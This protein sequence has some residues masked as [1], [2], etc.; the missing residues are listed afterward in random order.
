PASWSDEMILR[1]IS[2]V[3]TDR[4]S[5]FA[6]RAGALVAAS[7]REGVDIEVIIKGGRI[8]TGYPTNTPKNPPVKHAHSRT[9]GHIQHGQVLRADASVKL[10]AFPTDWSNDTILRH[11]S[12]VASDPASRFR[13]IRS[14]EYVATGRRDGVDMDVTI[15]R[16]T[17]AKA[18][19]TNAP[20]NP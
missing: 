11:I 10:S 5:V 2:D 19:P 14:G 12:E 7:N 3:A 18:V 13:K 4:T 17:I 1:H 6:T 9:P 8:I 15:R 20:R 16:G